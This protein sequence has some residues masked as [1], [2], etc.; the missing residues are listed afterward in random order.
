MK[1]HHI[2]HVVYQGYQGGGTP[3]PP[4]EAQTYRVSFW[5]TLLQLRCPVS[6]CL[7]G[8]SNWSNLQVHFMHRHLKDTIMILEEGDRPYPRCPKCDMFVYHRALNG[9]HLV[10]DLCRWG[11]ERNQRRLVE[12]EAMVGS[13]TV[14][15][16]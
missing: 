13:E 7:G 10:T 3:P 12:E 16:A 4:G 15:T 2:K 6:G 9:R 11:E 8:A 14:I 5:K 1:Q